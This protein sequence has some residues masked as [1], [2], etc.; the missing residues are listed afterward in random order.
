MPRSRRCVNVIRDQT[1]RRFGI[2]SFTGIP[3]SNSCLSCKL[4]QL[5]GVSWRRQ[6]LQEGHQCRGLDLED[7]DDRGEDILP[8]RTAENGDSTGL[9]VRRLIQ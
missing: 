5:V 7:P 4:P 6:A 8:P 1:A 9:V 2:V 3:S